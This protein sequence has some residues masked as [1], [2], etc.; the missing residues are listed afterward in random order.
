MATILLSLSSKEDKI[1]H[2]SEV[3][4][5]FLPFHGMNLRSKTGIFIYP[6]HFRYFVNRTAS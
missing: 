2:R 3:L 1:T 6:R 4:L 5:R